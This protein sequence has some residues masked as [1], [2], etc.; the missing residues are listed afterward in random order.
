MQC[1]KGAWISNVLHEGIG[2]P[3]LVDA[4][5]NETLTGGNIGDTNAEAERRAREKG[6]LEAKRK[7]HFQSMDEIGETAIS[8]T[9]G[10]MVIEASKAVQPRSAAVEAAWTSRLP[11]LGLGH[12]EQRLNALGIQTIWAYGF[13]TFFLI[14]CIF[15]YVRRKLRWNPFFAGPKRG[16]KFSIPAQSTTSRQRAWPWSK[17]QYHSLEDGL[18]LPGKSASKPVAGSLRL[19]SRRLAQTI[20]RGPW[21]HSDRSRPNRH[22]SLPLTSA[23]YTR[24]DG[25][26]SQPPSPL[27]SYFTPAQALGTT[28][29]TES[30]LS[31][32]PS[33]V[34]G[35][36][37]SSPPRSKAARPSKTRQN[38]HTGLSKLSIPDGNGSGWNDPPIMMLGKE[39]GTR[40]YEKGI[41]RQSSR[42]NLSEIGLAQRSSSRATTPHDFD[43]ATPSR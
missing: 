39:E 38:S 31:S 20:R 14:I 34:T 3:R 23:T 37:T 24:N 27:G 11:D 22:A 36:S 26:A 9:L 17:D 16:R 2:I 42:V 12:V 4:G 35:M 30:R 8:W 5:G 32:N 29:P 18:D 1:F 28:S 15:N 33:S 25:W 43:D 13:M 6:L 7:H 40:S 10:K 19:F 41:S 21:T